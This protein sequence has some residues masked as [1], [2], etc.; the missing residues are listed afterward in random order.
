MT[1]DTPSPT[2]VAVPVPLLAKLAS[3]QFAALGVGFG[4]ATVVV[5]GSL[6]RDGILPMT[7]WGFRALDGPLARIGTTQ[8]F[9]YGGALA[10]SELTGLVAG[11]GLWRGRRWAG[12]LGL[13]VTPV[14][15]ALGVGFELPFLLIGVPLRVL[16]LLAAWRHLR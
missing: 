2:D 12:R 14:S 7:P 16:T 5:L 9:V 13:A 11:L 8:T 1:V 10:A 6:A 15:L 3:V 4:A